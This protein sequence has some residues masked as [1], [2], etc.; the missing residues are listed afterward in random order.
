MFGSA[1]LGRGG[2]SAGEGVGSWRG[3]GGQES[4]AGVEKK[5]VEDETTKRKKVGGCRAQPRPVHFAVPSRSR[6]SMSQGGQRLHAGTASRFPRGPGWGPGGRLNGEDPGIVSAGDHPASCPTG[7]WPGSEEA[8]EAA[9]PARCT[10]LRVGE[11]L[12]RGAAF[13]LPGSARSWR[14]LL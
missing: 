5:R 2:R 1:R 7:R 14:P 3:E 11:I 8:S 4:G 9:A 13:G 12:Q 6:H 10:G